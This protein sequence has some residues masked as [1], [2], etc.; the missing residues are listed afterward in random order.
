MVLTWV[1]R[2]AHT[3]GTESFWDDGGHGVMYI[4][5]S[6]MRRI[7]AERWKVYTCSIFFFMVGRLGRMQ[8][9]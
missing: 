1:F 6:T 5:L 9:K 2:P 4:C 3:I 7:F 8:Y